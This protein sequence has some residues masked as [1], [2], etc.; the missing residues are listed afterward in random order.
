MM[1]AESIKREIR[2]LKNAIPI[3]QDDL[4]VYDRARI[5]EEIFGSPELNAY[6]KAIA[7]GDEKSA[8]DIYMQIPEDRAEL[9]LHCY[10]LEVNYFDKLNAEENE[11]G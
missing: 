1:N 5:Y 4:S 11:S 10:D 8:L 9:F 6:K 3:K 2:D 7:E